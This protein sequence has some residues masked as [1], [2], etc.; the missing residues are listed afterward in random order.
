MKQLLLSAVL[1]LTFYAS[2]AQGY[3]PL[4]NTTEWYVMVASFGGPNYFTIQSEGTEMIN[5]ISYSKFTG[6]VYLREDVIQK[7]VY[8]YENGSEFLLF[9]FTLQQG[10]FITLANGALYQV[11]SDTEIPVNGGFRRKL[12]LARVDN[13]GYDEQWIEGI[14]NHE[15]PLRARFEYPSDPVYYL[16]CSYENGTPVYNMGIANGV[17]PTSCTSLVLPT[18]EEQSI[19]A[20]PNPFFDKL[21]VSLQNSFEKISYLLYNSLGQIVD[22]RDILN[23][24]EFTLD[25]GN[26]NPGIYFMHVSINNQGYRIK[27][28]QI[29]N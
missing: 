17:S 12:Y 25:R 7:K 22:S 15:H 13:I 14:G 1:A 18:L 16:M 26:L 5:G 8:K 27:K 9:D 4:L 21:T 20:F 2:T 10:D 11:I 19:S 24:S 29:S 3:T 6:D 28:L 23:A